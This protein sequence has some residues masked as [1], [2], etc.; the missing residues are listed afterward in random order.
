[1]IQLSGEELFHQPQN[2]IWSRI[3]NDE[4]L[5]KC[6]PQ[7]E[8]VSRDRDGRLV[9]RVRAG[10]SFLKGTL[11]VTLDVYDTQEPCSARIR[12]HSKGIGS[13]AVVD[14]TVELSAVEAATTQLKWQAEVV[15]LGGLLKPVSRDLIG[16]TAQRV[17]EDGWLKFRAALE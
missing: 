3:C 6:L 10:V 15:E 14:S 9:C 2:E 13:L 1:M 16:A 7:V 12:V 5:V 11:K 8:S 17:I 4:F